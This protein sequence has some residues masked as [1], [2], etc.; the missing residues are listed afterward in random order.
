MAGVAASLGRGAMTNHFND[1]LNSDVI[2]IM[3]TNPS[4]NHPIA[5]KWIM[6]AKDKGAK[7]ISVDPRMNKSAAHADIFVRIRPGT[8]LAILNGMIKYILEKDLSFNE[9]VTQYTNASYLINQEFSF[10]DGIFSG[11]IEE[12]GKHNYQKD[13]WQYQKDGE[14]IK[15]DP[16]LQHPNCV[17]QHLKRHMARYDVSTVSRVT[18]VSEATLEQAYQTFA[19]TGKPNKAGNILWAMG[20]TQS[21]HGTQ[22][23]RAINI[24]QLLLG[25]IGIAGGGANAHR[26]ESNV[27]GSTD[28]GLLSHNLAGYLNVPY[29]QK[30]PDLAAYIEKETPKSSYWTNKPKFLI[31]MLKAWYGDKVTSENE[32]CYH[33]LPKHDSQNRYHVGIFEKMA[34][35]KIKGMFAWGQNPAVGGP[36]AWAE[37][38]AMEQLDWLVAVELFETET[39]SFWKRPGVNPA[40]IKTE[41]FFLPAAFSFEKEG[42][43]TNSGRWIQYRWK[44]VEPLGQAKSDTWIMNKLVNQI[45]KEYEQGGALPDPI[46][47]LKWDYPTNSHGEPEIA[48]VATELNGYDVKTG[49]P[50]DSF[51]KLKDDGTTA[52]GCWIYTGYWYTAEKY[53]VPNCQRRINKDGSGIGSFLEWSFAWPANR[54]ILY[55]RCSCDVSGKPWNEKLPVVEWN[56]NVWKT[57]DVPDFAFKDAKTGEIFPPEKSAL[58]PFLMIEEG[59]GRIWAAGLADGPLPEHYEPVESP[60]KNL[61]SAQQNNPN[62]V[63]YTGDFSR[64]K[65]MIADEKYPIIATT[66]RV[67]EHYQS[68]AVTRNSPSLAEAMPEMFVSLSPSLAKKLNIAP[69]D[70]V[71]VESVRGKIK[72]RASVMPVVKPLKIDGKIFEVIGMPW[73]FGYRGLVTGESANDLTPCAGDPNTSMPEFKAFMVNVTKA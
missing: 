60:V 20:I 28:M 31:S 37:R 18:G 66:H 13:T 61:L 24:I 44:A 46:L 30:H 73:H 14:T 69:G 4:E 59:V 34:Q 27:Q 9:Y 48:A 51:S 25:N 50:L 71:L 23:V 62:F 45:K 21:T 5:M 65:T 56:G 10:S 8:D 72:C 54:R 15:K 38:K 49:A 33:W 7:V 2:L 41:C 16:T 39:A 43:V 53:K 58:N 19:E 35:G 36:T 40:D 67:V 26:G 64:V 1:Y 57:N 63:Q 70:F 47:A 12:N 11:L 22:N 29:A 55:N 68:G 32:F 6:R 3:G 17:Y 52:C 42:T